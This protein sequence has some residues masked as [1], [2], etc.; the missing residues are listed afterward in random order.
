MLFENIYEIGYYDKI[1]SIYRY[2]IAL[3]LSNKLY[4]VSN[5]SSLNLG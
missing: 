2:I 3:I 1:Y 4:I 5:I